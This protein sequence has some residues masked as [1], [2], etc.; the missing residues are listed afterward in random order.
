MTGWFSFCFGTNDHLQRLKILM[1]KIVEQA[2]GI[3][4]YRLRKS[5]R[6]CRAGL[7][8]WIFRT[9]TCRL[10]ITQLIYNIYNNTTA[11]IFR[12]NKKYV[13]R[14]RNSCK[15]SESKYKLIKQPMNGR[16]KANIDCAEWRRVENTSGGLFP[17]VDVEV[18]MI[19]YH[20]LSVYQMPMQLSFQNSLKPPLFPLT[21]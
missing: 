6:Y 20:Y 13:K 11:T 7:S 16:H 17:A 18:M 1:E 12:R 5:F 10:Q 19:T 14:T 21:H 3:Y 4:I 8:S 9:M 2:S 15:R